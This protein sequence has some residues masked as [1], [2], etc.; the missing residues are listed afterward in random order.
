MKKCN[1]G[2]NRIV[3]VVNQEPK[4]KPRLASCQQPMIKIPCS[5]AKGRKSRARK[6]DEQENTTAFSLHC[7]NIRID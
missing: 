4:P 2:H 1:C 6:Q 7:V 5:K 3:P